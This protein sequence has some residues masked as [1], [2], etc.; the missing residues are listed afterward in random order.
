MGY[1]ALI[2]SLHDLIAHP[3]H[4]D[5]L[6]IGVVLEF[7]TKSAD[8]HLDGMGIAPRTVAPDVVH[9]LLARE[10]PTGIGRHLIKKHKLL[11]R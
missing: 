1:F 3:A 9:E 11:L 10:D 4:R 5:D 6:K 2:S 7:F 8:M